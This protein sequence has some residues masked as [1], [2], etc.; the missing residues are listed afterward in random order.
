[1]LKNN[2]FSDFKSSYKKSKYVIFGVPFDNTSTFRT[3][4]RWAPNSI[5]KISFNFESYNHYHQLDM[6]KIP[7][8]DAGN[9]YPSFNI[10]DAIDEI[11]LETK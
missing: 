1:M 8:H 6:K 4:S 2:K 9:I 10:K 7:V 11:Y 3:G 5:R